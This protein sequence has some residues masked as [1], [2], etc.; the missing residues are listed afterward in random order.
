MTFFLFFLGGLLIIFGF[1]VSF[2]TLSF[3]MTVSSSSGVFSVVGDSGES[4]LL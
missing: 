1:L 2:M 3:F 4:S